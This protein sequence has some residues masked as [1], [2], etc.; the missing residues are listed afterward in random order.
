MDLG[1]GYKPRWPY[2]QGKKVHKEPITRITN[3]VNMMMPNRLSRIKLG[4]CEES[5]TASDR[6][7]RSQR[8]VDQIKGAAS[9]QML[10]P[11]HQQHAL[12]T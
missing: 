3:G 6:C 10:I 5:L 11:L 4:L 12:K 1:L 8:S 9:L 7:W 2:N